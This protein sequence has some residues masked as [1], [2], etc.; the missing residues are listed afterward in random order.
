MNS[1]FRVALAWMCIAPS[2]VLADVKKLACTFP[3]F[4]TSLEIEM[5][6]S[7]GFAL[8]FTFDTTSNDA[9]LEGN[10]GLSPVTILRGG[11][12]L[13]FVEFLQTGAL[14]STTV[15]LDGSAVH[16][17]HTIIGS[18]LTPSQYYGSCN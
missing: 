5:L 12:G 2:L 15:A 4:H 13:T 14:Q 17:R 1:T 11:S 8:S 6:K 16:S 18:Q 9:F 10:S 7:N 3:T